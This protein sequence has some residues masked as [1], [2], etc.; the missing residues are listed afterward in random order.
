[1]Y[2]ELRARRFDALL[3]MQ[4]SLRAS[5]A[6]LCVRSPLRVGF[7]RARAR[8]LQWL[9]TN[10]RIAAQ[11]DQH[12]QDALLGFLPALGIQPGALEW[13]LP[14]P[15]EAL[16][17]AAALIPD[18]QP[19]LVISPCASH[20]AR[21]WRAE[22]YAALAAYAVQRYRMRVVLCG[23]RA[24]L[25]REL[26]LAI[27]QQAG[28][29]LHN[30]IGR[31]TLPQLLALL[32]RA[33]VLLTPDSGPAHMATMVGTPVIGLYAATRLQRSGPYFSRQWSIDRFEQA[34]QRYRGCSAAQLPWHAKIER[35][36]V[37]DLIELGDVRERLDALLQERGLRPATI[38]P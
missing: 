11:R 4:L 14:L 5:L 19:T 13:N 35:Q 31:D 27:E 1:L 8:E 9:F 22:R 23:G 29:P 20:T 21:N 38:S 2:A 36:G 33:T 26:G 24:P 16:E 12:V 34:A 6:S 18:A 10:R 15:A 28:V 7:D 32:A 30:Q 3:H 17:Y 25:E 37:M